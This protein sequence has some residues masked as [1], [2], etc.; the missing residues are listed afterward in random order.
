MNFSDSRI[1]TEGKKQQT[2]AAFII[3]DYRKME[4]QKAQ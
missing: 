2:S 3:M 1:L 4:R